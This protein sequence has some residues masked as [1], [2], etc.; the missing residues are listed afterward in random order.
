MSFIAFWKR[1]QAFFKLALVTNLEYRLNFFIDTVLQP[2][3]TTAIEMFL[4]FAIFKTSSTGLINGFGR[5]YYLSYAMWAAFFARISASWMYEFAMTEEI[6]SGSI[7]TILVRPVSF[8]EY[9]FSQLMG[10]KSITTLVSLMIPLMVGFFFTLP[11]E[12]SRLPMTLLLVFYYLIMVHS[13][14]FIISSFAFFLNK[15]HS[16]TVTKNLALWV[17]TGELFPLDLMPEKIKSIFL[18]LPFPSG[19]YIPVGYLTGRIEIDYVYRGFAS[20]TVGLIVFNLLG[21]LL[22]RQGLKKYAGTG[23]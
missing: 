12:V 11:F 2:S 23:A 8:Y 10:Y 18:I 13:I 1:N 4:W 16:F 19:V 14:S 15:V 5:E 21:F 7:N 6:E 22:W 9:Y 20:V 17:L 3:L